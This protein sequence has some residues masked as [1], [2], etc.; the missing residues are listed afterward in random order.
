MKRLAILAAAA[1]VLLAVVPVAAAE[2]PPDAVTNGWTAGTGPRYG[3]WDGDHVWHITDLSADA[4]C[5]NDT[6]PNIR[7]TGRKMMQYSA[8]LGAEWINLRVTFTKGNG[9]VHDT[10]VVGSEYDPLGGYTLSVPHSG[11]WGHMRLYGGVADPP[12]SYKL[13]GPKNG[14]ISQIRAIVSFDHD[15]LA[16]RFY[17]A[18]RAMI[19][20]E[21][22]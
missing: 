20:C 16:Q 22:A 3:E 2:E 7:L 4:D 21:D 18:P 6:K 15:H 9:Q 17:L 12:A 14:G 1:A 11:A 5:P 13:V 10:K 8:F 19:W